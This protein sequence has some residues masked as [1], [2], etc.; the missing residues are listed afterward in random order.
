MN[1]YWWEIQWKTRKIHYFLTHL[2]SI[3]FLGRF[4]AF[5][6]NKM[7]PMTCLTYSSTYLM[8]PKYNFKYI[9]NDSS[10]DIDE[11]SNEK[12]RK[13]I[14]FQLIQGRSIFRF[15]FACFFKRKCTQWPLTYFHLSNLSNKHT[16]I[17][18]IHICQTALRSEIDRKIN[19]FHNVHIHIA[20]HIYIYTLISYIY[21]SSIQTFSF[22]HKFLSF[23][24]IFYILTIAKNFEC[25]FTIIQT[26]L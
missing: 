21:A 3:H 8:T 12:T 1:V 23:N 26:S 18:C 17:L 16:D 5:F 24:F 9:L 22:T 6:L 11:K 4:W 20:T 7:Y 15:D 19:K 14:I 2:R 13:F 25:F 10:T